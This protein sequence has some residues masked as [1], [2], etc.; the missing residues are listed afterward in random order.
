M[1][2]RK[3]FKHYFSLQR[4]TLI[5]KIKLEQASSS[6][7]LIKGLSRSSLKPDQI[8]EI[9]EDVEVCEYAEVVVDSSLPSYKTST[10]DKGK[11]RDS[12]EP[13]KE[14]RLENECVESR[15]VIDAEE[16]AHLK[17]IEGDEI[18]KEKLRILT[19]DQVDLEELILVLT[20]I[21]YQTEVFLK[22]TNKFSNT[23]SSFLAL[24]HF[25]SLSTASSRPSTPPSPP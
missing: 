3:K 23:S 24:E 6:I 11:K 13:P 22:K 2:F 4:I 1:F 5:T 10:P 14:E 7:S 17:E 21:D 16:L 20:G 18:L 19:F 15:E 12:L 9:H 8:S 25:F